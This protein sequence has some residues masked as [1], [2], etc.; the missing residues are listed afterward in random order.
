MKRI[1]F[2][3]CS[4]FFVLSAVSCTPRPP[5][6]QFVEDAMRAV[7]GRARV[8]AVKSIAIEGTGVNYNLGQD[9]KPEAATQQFE[10]T[11]YKRQIDVEQGRQR[12]DQTRTPKFAYFQGPQP[13][14]QV[15]VL[16]GDIAFNIGA[17]GTPARVGTGLAER[18]RRTEYFHHP[19]TALKAA[20][21]PSNV[22]TISN[23]RT[24][25]NVR[26]ADF[27]FRD[28]Q[29]TMT[30]DAAG[31]PL[32]ISTK[33]YNANLGDVV[34][35]TTFADYQDTNGLKMP[36]KFTGKVD[37]FTTYEIVAS[38]QSIDTALG[39][40]AAPA[41]VLKPAPPAAPNVTAES[42]GKGVWFLA[43]QS[44]HSVLVEFDDHLM[45]IEA[46]QSEAR[47]LAVIKKARDTV[48]KKP[49]TE[50]VITHHH[51][52]HTAGLR[53]AIAEGLTV[54]TQTG[55]KAWVEN[56][57]RRPHTLQPDLLAKNTSRLNV[58]TVDEEKEFRDRTNIVMLYHVAGN[59]HS[60]TMLMAYLPRD[61]VLVEV[62]AFSPG[63]QVNP[64]A[65]NLLENI[66]K[67]NL[68]VD[69]IVPLHGA[70]APF[71]ELVKVS[72]GN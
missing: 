11:G 25:G 19:I 16:D 1:A 70:I 47:T 68:R 44:H 18:D 59:P 26:Q 60:G 2:V 27:A 58:V 43:G 61:R 49:L 33:S 37:D 39:D 46:P 51:F 35:T 66:Q 65:A 17:N 45:L 6:Q 13:Q 15:Q 71:A 8:E 24:V 7:G 67:R 10:I 20:T 72:K 48:P 34:L 41:A 57:A 40:M 5:E 30:I 31:L 69:K 38:Q 22:T 53:A 29:W 55:N 63:A 32:S 14:T 3:L 54:I 36:A 50:L 12:V 4:S 56:M 62:D 28:R 9:M 52:D 21:A 42:V 23:V 64:Y